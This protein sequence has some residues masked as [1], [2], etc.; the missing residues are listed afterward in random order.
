MPYYGWYWDRMTSLVS[1][2]EPRQKWHYCGVCNTDIPAKEG[3]NS[4][5]ILIGHLPI[6]PFPIWHHFPEDNAI[7]PCITGWCKLPVSNGFRSCPPDRDLTS[8]TERK[9]T[10]ILL[11]RHSVRFR[12]SVIQENLL[13]FFFF[14]I[15]LL[16]DITK[17]LTP[18]IIYLFWQ[19]FLYYYYITTC[20]SYVIL[21]ALTPI[22]WCVYCMQK[23]ASP[24]I[25]TEY[26]SCSETSVG[27]VV[28]LSDLNLRSRTVTVPWNVVVLWCGG[29]TVKSSKEIVFVTLNYLLFDTGKWE[30]LGKKGEKWKKGIETF[31]FLLSFLSSWW[32]E[33]IQK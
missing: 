12:E 10:F 7:A 16:P 29:P 33:A 2:Y 20:C 9:G 31:F 22:V 11:V 1:E 23:A 21:G 15:V 28:W 4:T 6:W 19:I 8:L 30:H 18:T 27:S 32:H 24:E 25:F 17:Y 5:H 26:V 13:F 14:L 3:N